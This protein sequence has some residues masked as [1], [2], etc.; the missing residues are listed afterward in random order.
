MVGTTIDAYGYIRGDPR[1][2]GGILDRHVAGDVS[3]Q[4][5]AGQH[6]HRKALDQIRMMI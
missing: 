5:A 4:T 2:D 1:R 3:E 6:Q